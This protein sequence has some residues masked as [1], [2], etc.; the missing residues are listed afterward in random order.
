MSG[1]SERVLRNTSEVVESLADSGTATAA[2]V[3]ERLELSRTT[4]HRLIETLA[5]GGYVDQ[6]HGGDAALS[7]RWLH[8]ADAARRG[9]PEWAGMDDVLVSLVA[10]TG[11]TA[12]M[13]TPYRGQML[14]VAWRPG[15]GI[16]LL[17]YRPGSL[18]PA[19]RGAA[20]QVLAAFHA[21]SAELALDPGLQAVRD[22][23]YALSEGDVTPGIGAVGV[24]LFSAS[25]PVNGA[26]SLGGLVTDITE[27][28]EELAQVLMTATQHTRRVKIDKEHHG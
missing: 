18:L 27:R 14:C 3:A 12:F 15:R 22:R 7:G 25:G 2:E 13:S 17:N 8:L 9:N 4:V 21:D 28:A 5:I 24:P 11:Q 6:P 10:Q 23:G 1:S 19:R 16:D 26:L 20:G